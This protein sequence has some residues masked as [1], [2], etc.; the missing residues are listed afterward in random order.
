VNGELVMLYKEKEKDVK[1]GH[2]DGIDSD[3]K[4]GVK[5]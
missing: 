1:Q 2:Y 3:V 5:H 4:L